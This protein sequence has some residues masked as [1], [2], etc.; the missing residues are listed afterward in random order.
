MGSED[1]WIRFREGWDVLLWCRH[2]LAEDDHVED[3]SYG[4]NPNGSSN[5]SPEH[6]LHVKKRR[7]ACGHRCHASWRAVHMSWV[8]RRH[9]DRWNIWR[10]RR[11]WILRWTPSRSIIKWIGTRSWERRSWWV[12]NI[13]WDWLQHSG[14]STAQ[15]T[16]LMLV[17]FR[18]TKR[19]SSNMWDVDARS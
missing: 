1:D 16:V 2:S 6:L 15:K 9:F 4:R 12:S 10:M 3:I 14:A 7:H 13:S 17:R 18:L 11:G 8:Y 19:E 5:K